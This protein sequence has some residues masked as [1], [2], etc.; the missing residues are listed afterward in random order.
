V[1]LREGGT[2]PAFWN[3]ASIINND[4]YLVSNVVDFKVLIYTETSIETGVADAVNVND[5]TGVLDFDYMYGGTMDGTTD[6]GEFVPNEAPLYA[7]IVL[8]I[9]SDEGLELLQLINDPNYPGDTSA[10]AV[11]Q[12]VREH[13]EVFTRRVN[14]L[15]R[16]L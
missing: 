1:T 13:G 14:F 7:D 11:N 6:P 10:T 2:T 12:I 5:A 4:N 15:A 3:E 9:V 8:T 16:P